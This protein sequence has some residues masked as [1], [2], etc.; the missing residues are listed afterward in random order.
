MEIE[1]SIQTDPEFQGKVDQ[2]R[3]S[4]LILRTLSQ[5]DIPTPLSLALLVTDDET[6][7]EL[8]LTYRGQD[9]ETDVL[10][11]GTNQ[12]QSRFISAPSVTP[13]LGDVVVSFPR[14][15]AQAEEYGCSVEQELHRLVVHGLLHLLGYDDQSG[16]ERERMWN[17][18]ETILL[19]FSDN[20]I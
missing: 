20:A 16:E 1:L 14:A 6:I 7:K 5:E 4:E 8:N 3:V 2:E 11:F 17:K 19:G 9:S 10:A 12:A 18:Q 13:H 15:V